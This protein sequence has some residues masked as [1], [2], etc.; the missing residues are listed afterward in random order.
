M[1]ESSE[2]GVA[3]KGPEGHGGCLLE[4]NNEIRNN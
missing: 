3:K 2:G 4:N 1:A